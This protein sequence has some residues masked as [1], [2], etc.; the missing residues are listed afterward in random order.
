M[1]VHNPLYK[2]QGIHVI[3]TIFTI[4]KGKA[5][6]LLIRRKY[7]PYEG[8]WALVG[9][10]LYNNETI[11]EGLKREI[12]EKTGI[13][14]IDLILCNVFGKID[15]SPA[16]R[17][18]GISFMGVLDIEKV[19]IL[20]ETYKTI[21]SDWFSIDN[22]PK[23]LAF[24]HKE[25]INNALEVL[26]EQIINTNILKAFFPNGFTIPEIQK[27]YEAV[28][29]KTYDRRNFRKKIINSDLIIDTNKY[30]TFEGKKPAKLYKFK[31]KHQ[32][33]NIF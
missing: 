11:E 25:V 8:M 16:M 3:A 29:N 5:K 9:G 12:R 20:K 23:E 28:F 31:N 17:M 30:A 22:L 7:N 18:V 26:K 27:I 33:K 21:D 15:R 13:E 6:I 19:N 4:D 10:A 32:D 2:N 14:K 1:E 24:D